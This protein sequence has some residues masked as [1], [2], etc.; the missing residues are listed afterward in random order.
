MGPITYDVVSLFRDAFISWEEDQEIDWVVRYWEKARAAGLPV[1]AEF[2]E[3]YRWFEWMGVQRHLKVAGIFA[4][5]SYRDGKAKYRPE[6]PRFLNYL[7]RASRRYNDLVPLYALL[8]ELVGDEEL[9]T[10]F[11][12]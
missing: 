10:G 6:I 12:F 3:F 4:R 11:T 8:V 2:D 7:R 9:E 5:L 1:P